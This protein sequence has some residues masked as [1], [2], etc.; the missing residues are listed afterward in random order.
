[1][2]YGPPPPK[3]ASYLQQRLHFAFF[4]PTN[5]TKRVQT[6]EWTCQ[7]PYA[8]ITFVLTYR[9]IYFT[10]ASS[11][12]E[13][14]QIFQQLK[15]FEGTEGSNHFPYL[16]D[17]HSWVTPC[18]CTNTAYFILPNLP[19]QIV[20]PSIVTET[21]QARSLTVHSPDTCEWKLACNASWPTT[22]HPGWLQAPIVKGREEILREEQKYAQRM[23]NT[24]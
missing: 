18:I 19:H 9:E 16:M 5:F 3:Y 11:T 24:V 6:S 15:T 7:S 12:M 21:A 4:F 8:I 23:Y 2:Q 20:R 1:M 14:S 10:C 22:H 17:T 13:W